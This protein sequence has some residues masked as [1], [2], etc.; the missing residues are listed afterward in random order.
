MLVRI[1]FIPVRRCEVSIVID[2]VRS[3][4]PKD[5]GSSLF[6]LFAYIF[7]MESDNVGIGNHE[8]EEH[9]SSSHSS[10]QEHKS[11]AEFAKD[12]LDSGESLTLFLFVRYVRKVMIT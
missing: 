3:Q 7:T 1:V 11:F 12:K 10:P 2:D 8:K 6:R 9:E 5:F 4:S